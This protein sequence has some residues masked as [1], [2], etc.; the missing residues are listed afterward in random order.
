MSGI[1]DKLK[2]ISTPPDDKDSF[3]RWIQGEDAFQFLHQNAESQDLVVHAI[4][5]HTYVHSVLVPRARL[6]EPRVDDLLNWQMNACDSWNIVSS[7]REPTIWIEPPLDA[8][9]NQTFHQAEQILFSRT[10]EGRLGIPDYYELEQKFAHIFGLHFLPERNAYCRFNQL[11]DIENIVRFLCFPKRS[12]A[13]EPKLATMNRDLLDDYL[14]LTDSAIVLTF[15]FT[16]YRP[17]FSHWSELSDI[18][19]VAENGLFF[20]FHIEEGR[21]S[22]FRGA[23]IVPPRADK[24]SLQERYGLDSRRQEKQYASFIA[25]DWKNGVIEEI[26]CAPGATSNYFTKSELPFELSPAFFRPEVLL[27]YKADSEKYRLRDRTIKCRGAWYLKTYDINE[28]GQVHTYL[29]YL[30]DLPYEEQ[31]YWKSYNEPPK[32][33]LSKRAFKTDFEGCWHTEYDALTSLVQALRGLHDSKVPWWTLRSEKLL[34]QVHYPVT[35]SADEWANEVLLLD[36]LVVEGFETKWLRNEAQKRGRVL[37]PNFASLKVTEELLLGLGFEALDAS[38]VMNPLR[39]LHD[40]R[41]KLKGHASGKEALEIR[42]QV[43]QEYG[44]FKGHVEALCTECDGTMR[45][46]AEAMKQLF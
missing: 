13:I 35:S 6:D 8:P 45:R 17:P 28:A 1:V 12:G 41:S 19:A 43:L 11:G 7:S 38:N 18:E 25:I 33:P 40:L 30:R 36:Q 29:V 44:N 20:R 31:L 4:S 34:E 3:D 2:A 22:Y 27:K 10:F 46:I 9:Q 14:L 39:F 21:A 16:R 42:Q 5:D 26:S 24:E 23:Q 32:G 37:Q 15:D